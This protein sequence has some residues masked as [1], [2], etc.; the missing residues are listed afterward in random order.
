MVPSSEKP[1]RV[2][3]ESVTATELELAV[4][5]ALC[6]LPGNNATRAKLAH[7]LKEYRWEQADHRVIYQAFIE[8]DA[9]DTETLRRELPAA[10][11]R[12]G[13]PDIQW[14][15]F[16]AAT[17]MPIPTDRISGLIRKLRAGVSGR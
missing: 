11:T 15:R 4:L 8:T 13:F 7:E 3:A 5:R 12:M 16:F 2:S 6:T 10:V 14:E 9:G 17:A 1:H